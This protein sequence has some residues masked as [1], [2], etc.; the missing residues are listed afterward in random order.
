MNCVVGRGN[1][2]CGGKQGEGEWCEGRGSVVVKVGEMSGV[3]TR[4]GE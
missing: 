2:W 4:E 3:E 1:E